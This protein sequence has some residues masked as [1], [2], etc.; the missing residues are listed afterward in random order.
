MVKRL[1]DNELLVIIS[2][3]VFF[4]L[5]YTRRARVA[6]LGT[7]VWKTFDVNLAWIMISHLQKNGY[8]CFYTVH[9]DPLVKN[10][11]FWVIYT[12]QN[13]FY[14]FF[15]KTWCGHDYTVSNHVLD[16]R[17]FTSWNFAWVYE[18]KTDVTVAVRPAWF[19]KNRGRTRTRTRTDVR[20]DIDF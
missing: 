11:D 13:V 19:A 10:S 8:F 3:S 6:P 5:D 14:F 7:L 12:S 16:F 4:R 9:M 18:P 15:K 20:T 2:R 1:G 17:L